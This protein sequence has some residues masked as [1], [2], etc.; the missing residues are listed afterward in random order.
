M[1]PAT[2]R[3]LLEKSVKLVSERA[4]AKEIAISIAPDLPERTFAA[5][6]RRLTQVLVNLLANAVKFTPPGG[7][8]TA[9]CR[10]VDGPGTRE[11]MVEFSVSDTASAFPRTSFPSCS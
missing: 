8:V 3:D 9:G 1:R 2:A 10:T 6:E 11:E 7:K 4:R 5:D